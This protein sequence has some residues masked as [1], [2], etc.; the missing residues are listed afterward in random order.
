M[1]NNSYKNHYLFKNTI[2][3]GWLNIKTLTY[4][5]QKMAQFTGGG[6]FKF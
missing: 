6:A 5:T 2:G 3:V 4:Y 1:K